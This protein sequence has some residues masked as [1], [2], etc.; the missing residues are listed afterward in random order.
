MKRLDR[1]IIILKHSKLGMFAF[2]SLLYGVLFGGMFNISMVM[3][4]KETILDFVKTMYFSGGGYFCIFVIA[5]VILFVAQ[6]TKLFLSLSM[7]KKDI[8]K[9]WND[10]V[11]YMASIGSII[12]YSILIITI[13]DAEFLSKRILNMN[14]NA[15]ALVD[16]LKLFLIIIL[17]VATIIIIGSIIAAIGNNYGLFIAF[18]LLGIFLSLIIFSIPLIKTTLFWGDYLLIKIITL[19][20]IDVLLWFINRKLIYNTEVVR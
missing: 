11:L 4:K 19:I 7:P 2:I 3:H 12:L 6:N 15:M 13:N 10:L 8:F 14:I 9:I 5:I 17:V 1:L 20:L 18:G 16:H